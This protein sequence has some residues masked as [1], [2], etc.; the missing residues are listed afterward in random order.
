MEGGGRHLP[1]AG[2]SPA[3]SAALPPDPD[4][5]TRGPRRP[6]LALPHRRGRL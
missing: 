2:D 6:P 4:Q 1:Q 3:R 5:R